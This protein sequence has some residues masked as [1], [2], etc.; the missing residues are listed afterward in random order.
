MRP[1][2]M[3]SEAKDLY[4]NIA[5]GVGTPRLGDLASVGIGYVSGANDFFHLRPSDAESWVSSSHT[6]SALSVFFS[7]SSEPDRRSFN[8]LDASS[9]VASLSSV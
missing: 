1:F 2:L 9:G 6:I 5:D 4:R 7:R 3:S 8:T